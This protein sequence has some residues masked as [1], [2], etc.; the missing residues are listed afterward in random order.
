MD[1]I[2]FAYALRNVVVKTANLYL[3]PLKSILGSILPRD[4]LRN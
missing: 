4:D 2:S 1:R 3:S